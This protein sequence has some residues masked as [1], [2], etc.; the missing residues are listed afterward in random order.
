M[1]HFYGLPI[2]CEF[3]TAN[4]AENQ[5]VVTTLQGQFYNIHML[6]EFN[7]GDLFK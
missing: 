3:L 7:V 6:L 1:T 2:Q 5:P 4:S